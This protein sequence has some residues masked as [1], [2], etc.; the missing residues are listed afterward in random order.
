MREVDANMEVGDGFCVILAVYTAPAVVV[1]VVMV[2]IMVPVNYTSKV[3]RV[4]PFDVQV[5]VGGSVARE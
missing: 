4:R 1:M 3:F 5:K 2:S